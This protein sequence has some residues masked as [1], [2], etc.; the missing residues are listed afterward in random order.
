MER[1]LIILKPDT[2]QRG[3]AG[4]I[5]ARFENKGLKIVA[6]RMITISRELA[7]EHYSEHAEKPFF[8][9]VV[10]YITSGPVMLMILEGPSAITVIRQIVGATD[11]RKALPGTIRGDFGISTR[12]NLVHASDS[13][14]AAIREINIFFKE[15]EIENYDRVTQQWSWQV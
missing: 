10:R 12:Y 14:E 4:Q 7:Q 9:D 1:S 2:I 6:A 5:L 11:G 8:E 3:L 15:D 13:P